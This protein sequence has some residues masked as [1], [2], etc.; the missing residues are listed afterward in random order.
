M[1]DDIEVQVQRLQV[2][3]GDTLVVST[4][5]M[6]TLA[7]RESIIASL[8]RAL[9]AVVPPPGVPVI[10][11]DGGLVVSL[12]SRPVELGAVYAAPD[13]GGTPAPASMPPQ[14]PEPAVPQPAPT[15]RLCRRCWYARFWNSYKTWRKYL[16]V[17][18]SICAAWRVS[19]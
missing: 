15:V 14:A 11:M 1:H 7:Q 19:R 10:V 9:A 2:Q 18:D 6:L 3:P 8:K 13:E 17:L 4:E 12:I 5:K 16:G